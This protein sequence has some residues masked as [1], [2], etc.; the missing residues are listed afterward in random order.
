[1]LSALKKENS[2][3][4]KNQMNKSMQGHGENILISN[5]KIFGFI[6][7]KRFPFV[8]YVAKGNLEIFSLL[9]K[10]EGNLKYY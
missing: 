2:C 5:D 9:L 3:R 8:T 6:K 10:N 1:M 4:N 7:L